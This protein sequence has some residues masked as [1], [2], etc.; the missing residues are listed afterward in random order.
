[1]LSG[2][3]TQTHI[4]PTVAAGMPPI[5]TVGPPGEMIGPPTCGMGGTPGVTIGHTC[6]SMIR[7]ANI[8]Q[9]RLI[10][11][12]VRRFSTSGPSVFTRSNL[13]AEIHVGLLDFRGFG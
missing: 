11:F 13:F 10:R 3:P 1:M 8:N 2:G 12:G 9:Y 7:A 4:E 5:K 6:I